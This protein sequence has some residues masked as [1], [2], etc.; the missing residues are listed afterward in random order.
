MLAKRTYTTLRYYSQF[1]HRLSSQNNSHHTYTILSTAHINT[2][3]NNLHS[4]QSTT[5]YTNRTSLNQPILLPFHPFC[6]TT[7]NTKTQTQSNPTKV[8]NKDDDKP[9]LKLSFRETIE[10]IRSGNIGG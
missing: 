7:S 9:T 4:S 2:Y 8:S 6:T 1:A 5:Q 10:T 3:T